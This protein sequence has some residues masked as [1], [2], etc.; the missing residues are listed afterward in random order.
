MGVPNTHV[1]DVG[2]AAEA[3]NLYASPEMPGRA[4]SGAANT[5][6]NS[7]HMDDGDKYFLSAKVNSIYGTCRRSLVFDTHPCQQ[8]SGKSFST[9]GQTASRRCCS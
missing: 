1:D 9:K 3:R 5:T 4:G 6:N 8:K 7:P 2:M